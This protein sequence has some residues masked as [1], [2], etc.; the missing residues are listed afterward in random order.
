[1]G[2]L[3]KTD[4]KGPIKIF[5]KEKSYT[6]GTF[7]VYSTS[8][9]QKDTNGNWKSAWFDVRFPRSAD[10]SE[11]TNKCEINI[12][13]AFF[14]VSEYN[15]KTSPYIMVMDF[16]VAKQGELPKATS[17]DFMNLPEGM[18]DEMPFK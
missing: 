9:S 14:G 7:K 5:V 10:V 13:N 18:A 12:N 2:L 8:I 11:V 1:M 15:G 16:S 3:L 6:G 4:E 17:D